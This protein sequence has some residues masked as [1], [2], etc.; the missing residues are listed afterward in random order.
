MHL[1]GR[2]GIDPE[3]NDNLTTFTLAVDL[4]RKGEKSVF[5]CYCA[6]WGGVC[7]HQVKH[8]KKGKIINVVGELTEIKPYIHPTGHQGVNFSLNVLHFDFDRSSE[9]KL[10]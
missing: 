5:W 2:L 1:K 10:N 6:I 8:L 9:K 4:W 7:A 3:L